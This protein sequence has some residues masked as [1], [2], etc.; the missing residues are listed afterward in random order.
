MVFKYIYIIK[1]LFIL[2]TIFSFQLSTSYS[3][4]N[5]EIVAKV[6]HE[7]ISSKDLEEKV[8]FFRYILQIDKNLELNPIFEKFALIKLIE[9]KLMYQEIN[10]IDSNLF[11]RSNKV[12]EKLIIQRSGLSKKDLIKELNLFRF[13]FDSFVK[14]YSIKIAF[15][16]IINSKYKQRFEKINNQNSKYLKY[17][18]QNKKY[19]S[20]SEIVLKPNM[21]FSDKDNKILSKLIHNLILEDISFSNLSE[22]FSSSDSKL[23][24]GEKLWILL[25]EID[26]EFAVN[27]DKIKYGETSKPFK[28]GENY[29]I[30]LNNGKINDNEKDK[31]E[32]L[33]LLGRLYIKLIETYSENEIRRVKDLLTKNLK[34]VN[35]CKNLSELS[36]TFKINSE[37]QEFELPFIKIPKEIQKYIINLKINEFSPI[38]NS[39]NGFVVLIV[40]NKS[41]PDKKFP[42]EKDAASIQKNELLNKISNQYLTSLARK[43]KIIIN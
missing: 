27:L 13:S 19:I 18:N 43:A 4:N 39:T 16:S 11:Q 17:I 38:L 33:Y 31:N 28:I 41:Y 34:K 32:Y 3:K 24:K 30:I 20:Y 40:C 8:S 14:F 42:S 1:F 5:Y 37:Y 6:N 21:F 10:K 29:Y 35:N 25:D 26:E 9:D 12:S 22:L 36:K 23:N 15:N 7:I 2:L